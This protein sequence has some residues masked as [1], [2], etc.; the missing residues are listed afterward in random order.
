MEELEETWTEV[1]GFGFAG[2]ETDSGGK[3]RRVHG[4]LLLA[5]E[6]GMEVQV[7]VNGR[8][9]VIYVHEKHAFISNHLRKHL[10]VSYLLQI[11]IVT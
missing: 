1:V 10:E 2:G 4:E 3:F 11:V 9:H 7:L 8:T 6:L 5:V